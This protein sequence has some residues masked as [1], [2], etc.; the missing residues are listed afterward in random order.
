MQTRIEPWEGLVLAAAGIASAALVARGISRNRPARLRY[1]RMRGRQR[2]ET[3]EALSGGRGIQIRESI[4]IARPAEDLYAKWRDLEALPD[5]FRHVHNVR[6]VDGVRSRWTVVGPAGRHVSWDAELIADDGST[7]AWQSIPG[8]EVV[9]AGSVRFTPVARGTEM[10]VN[11]RYD[12]PGGVVGKWVAALFGKDP[13]GQIREDLRRFKQ[14]VE[15]GEVPTSAIQ[16]AG[17]RSAFFKAAEGW[18]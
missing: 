3:R 17:R 18:R 2:E 9:T 5:Y 8:S 10:V 15:T 4:T 7:I 14:I 1:G 16:P 11:I 13:A 6:E 12:P